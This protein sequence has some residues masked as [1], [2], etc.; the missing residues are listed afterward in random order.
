MN[1]QAPEAGIQLSS[2]KTTCASCRLQELCLPMG[3][4]AKEVQLLEKVVD[5]TPPISKSS[6]LFS[7][8]DTFRALYIPRSGALKTTYED[9]E[10][11]HAIIGFHLPGEIVGLDGIAEGKHSVTAQALETTSVCR[12][13]FDQ[14]E[15]VARQVPALQRQLG[16]LLSKEFIKAE[17]HLLVL[18]GQAADRRVAIFLLSLSNRFEERGFSA[19]E[20]NLPMSRIDI[21]AYLGLVS[22]TVSRIFTNL[23]EGRMIEVE[24][25][26]TRIIDMPAL[27]E[28]AGG[29]TDD[30]DAAACS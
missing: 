10:G 16:R 24:G 9:S 7:A 27:K 18:S 5:Q 20:F 19:S 25:R 8:G 12:V 4:S 15:E 28:L 2:L 17:R 26:L 23:Q 3:I 13:G 14:L 21:A 1:L 6:Y 30:A 29:G 11:N 22:E